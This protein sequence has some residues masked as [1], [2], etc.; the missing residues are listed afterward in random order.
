MARYYSYTVELVGTKYPG[1]NENWSYSC[2][3]PNAE[4]AK[5]TAARWFQQHKTPMGRK[6]RTLVSLVRKMR[7]SRRGI[8]HPRTQIRK[9]QIRHTGK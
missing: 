2:R 3:A 4:E 9:V 1:R 8:F 6:P 7:A 5:L